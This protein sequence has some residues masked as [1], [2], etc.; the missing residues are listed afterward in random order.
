MARKL[1]YT[2]S[3]VAGMAAAGAVLA[4]C[5]SASTA[6]GSG[7]PTVSGE[8]VGTSSVSGVGTVLVNSAGMTL[9]FTDQDHG[10]TVSCT[11]ACTGIWLPAL[12]SGTSAP[13]GSATGVTVVKRSD[14]GKEQ[15]A[16]KGKP[17]YEFKLDGMA[18]QVAG[19]GAHDQF[20]GTS[21]TWHAAVVPGTASSGAGNG[22]GAGAIPGY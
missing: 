16:Y 9:Y 5:G 21:F 3:A 6:T 2:L 22:G 7:S 11:A 17:L 13:S 8:A 14:D 19:N 15:L 20:G 4:A 10:A 12:T 1:R 18:G